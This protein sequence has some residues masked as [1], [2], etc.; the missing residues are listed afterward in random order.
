MGV[1]LSL[2]ILLLIAVFRTA[3]F[4]AD[5]EA[6]P[7]VQELYGKARTAQ[8][9]GDIAGAIADYEQ[10]LKVAPRLGPAYN[11]LGAL[12][13]RQHNYRKAASVLE[14]G[15]KISPTMPSASALLGISLYEMGEYTKARSRLE[16]ALRA[17]P[18]D[19]NAQMFLVKDLT[20]LGDSDAAAAQL[21]QLSARE[22][23]NQEVYLSTSQG[24]YENVR[25][26]P[27]QNECD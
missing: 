23:K 6:D 19:N 25:R 24:I 8:A 2:A 26:R 1:R 16:A 18:A 4:A 21:R 3:I 20:H 9:Q 27:G 13:F 7:R 5:S 17:N 12:Y 22:P 11:N 14:D 10:I 15:L